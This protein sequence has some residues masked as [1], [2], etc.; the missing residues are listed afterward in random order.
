MENNS[1]KL[2]REYIDKLAV[3]TTQKNVLH[4][5]ILKD[6]SQVPEFHEGKIYFVEKPSIGFNEDSNDVFVNKIKI[7]LKKFPGLFFI[8]YHL[9]G[10]SFVGKSSKK[11]IQEIP[12]GK[13]II[14]LGSGV[15]VVRED[16]V[17]IDFYP[18]ENVHIVA[19]ISNLPFAAAQV[20]AVLCEY[21][22]EHVPD[23]EAIVKEIERVTK[24]GGT[25][26][27]SVPFVASFHSSPN[28]YYRW[29]KMGLKEQLKNF[30]EVNSG[31]RSGPGAA[32]DYILAE[33]VATLFSFGSK[34]IH[35]VLFM[36]FLIL[37][38]P[39]CYLDYLIARYPTSE[40]IAYGFYYIGRKK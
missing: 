23:P 10:A 6:N 1:Q 15:T 22:L 26:Y 34:T 36:T 27:V 32:L 25:V 20:D 39:L 12:K 18:F 17:N 4:G 30:E 40:N 16:V 8:I 37:F 21:V 13:V 3:T 14:N 35:Q 7:F 29:S 19:D 11:S 9:V 24:P 31:V 5:I 28:D 38:A 2:F 33:F